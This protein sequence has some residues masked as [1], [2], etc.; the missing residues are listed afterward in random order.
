MKD[1]N[2]WKIFE[3]IIPFE[4]F[5][6]FL[7]KNSFN[8]DEK[9]GRSVQTKGWT[10]VLRHWLWWK[11]RGAHRRCITHFILNYFRQ[12]KWKF[13]RFWFKTLFEFSFVRQLNH[14]LNFHLNLFFVIYVKLWNKS[15]LKDVNQII[16]DS[17][18]Q[19][20]WVKYERLT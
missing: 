15:V 7:L 14:C 17:K 1:N 3:S 20:N 16:S 6:F 8:S 10:A 18:N 11:G 19:K 5:S 9:K 12:I 4:R 2:I 13:K